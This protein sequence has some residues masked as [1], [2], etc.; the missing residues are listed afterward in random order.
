MSSSMII[1]QYIPTDSFIH[2]LDPRSKIALIFFF[3]I[4]VFFAN[5]VWSYGVLAVFAVGSAL[6]SK[7]PFR[8]IMK[9]LKP[10][11]FLIIFT[12]LLHLFVT[13]QGEV[14]FSVFG[15]NVYEEGL[16]QGAAI[17]L[18]F[19][20]LILV[21]SL[22]TLT[23]TPIEITDAIEDLLGPLKKVRFPVHELALMM[24][25]SLRFIP[26][27]MQETEKISK[28]QASRGVDFRTGRFKDRVKAVVPLLVPLFVSAFKRAEELA[29][30]MEAR[31]YQGG[32]GRTKL[33]ELRIGR[34]DVFT[35]VVFAVVVLVLFLTR[36]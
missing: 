27:L 29:M 26:T 16:I 14:A 12:F 30:A 34:I 22:L 6:L 35:Y 23:T 4:V 1:G 25:I 24:S 21:T 18:R 15:W 19:F 11:W 8:Y 32:E 9:G 31:G 5:S 3:V 17:S 2:R 36:S 20:L 10:V 28:A 13:R 33:R 7:V